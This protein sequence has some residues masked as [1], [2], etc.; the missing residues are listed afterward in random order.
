MRHFLVLLLVS[1]TLVSCNQTEYIYN[2]G[3][4]FGTFYNIQYQSAQ[5]YQNEIDSVLSTVNQSLSTYDPTSVISK[6]NQNIPTELDNHFIRVFKAGQSISEQTGGAFDMTVSSLVNAWGFGFKKMEFPDST[7]ID[8]LM[9]F[10]GYRN[11][12]LSEN[13]ITKTNLNYEIDASAIAKGYGVDVVVELLESYQIENYLVEIGGEIRL[14]GKSPKNRNWTVGIDVPEESSIK[15]SS[16]LQ[17]AISVGEGAVATSGNYRQFYYKDGK[18]YAH[19]I[20]PQT[21]YPV[22]HNLLSATVVAPDCM[23]ADALATAAMVMGV[24]K[25]KELSKHLEGINF[26]LI[27]A[28]DSTTNEIWM[29]PGFEQFIVKPQ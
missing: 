3:Q 2:S 29:S 1:I 20:D 8:S 13:Q 24:E 9:S 25:T 4:V 15:L 17:E 21:G 10:V 16:N 6:V 28:K 27:Y 19:T 12:Q 23:S 14:K 11:I 18:K 5:D 26:Y 22:N 7:L